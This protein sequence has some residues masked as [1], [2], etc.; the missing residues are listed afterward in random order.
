MADDKRSKNGKSYH[1]MTVRLPRSVFESLKKVR[2][3]REKAEL[4]IVSYTEILLCSV[5][6]MMPAD[7]PKR[8]EPQRDADDCHVMTFRFPLA[9]LEHLKKLK[10]DAVASG[11]KLVTY[12]KILLS[13]LRN[14][15]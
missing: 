7:V 5:R 6:S 12:Q 11:V 8:R 10:A 9:D 3:R 13:G 14:A 4:R 2:A 15:S 1:V